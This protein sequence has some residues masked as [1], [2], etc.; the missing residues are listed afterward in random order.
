MSDK[1]IQEKFAGR[2]FRCKKTG[3]TLTIP[4]NVRTGQFFEFG[5]CFIDVGDTYYS[6]WGGDLEELI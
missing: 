5:D 1:T 4:S 2:E 6:R 3:E